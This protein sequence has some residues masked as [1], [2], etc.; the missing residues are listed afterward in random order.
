M[1]KNAN[2]IYKAWPCYKPNGRKNETNKWKSLRTSEHITKRLKTCYL[3]CVYF[4]TYKHLRILARPDKDPVLARSY[5]TN[6]IGK[7][8]FSSLFFL[9]RGRLYRK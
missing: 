6:A 2:N 3:T 9:V 7:T 1:K 8:I 5:V 4:M